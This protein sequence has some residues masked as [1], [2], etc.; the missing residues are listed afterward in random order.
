MI[1]DMHFEILTVGYCLLIF[2]PFFFMVTDVM[3]KYLTL[4]FLLTSHFLFILSYFCHPTNITITSNVLFSFSFYPSSLFF[5]IFPL[6]FPQFTVIIIPSPL[7]PAF[8][9]L[10]AFLVGSTSSVFLLDLLPS[11]SWINHIKCDLTF[12]HRPTS[13][14]NSRARFLGHPRVPGALSTEYRVL[15][16]PSFLPNVRLDSNQK[17]ERWLPSLISVIN[18]IENKVMK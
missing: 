10:F 9:S 11:F 2:S 13:L 3:I 1:A 4:L 7:F 16:L 12:V 18:R 6:T 17:P 8:C 5:H 14:F 15:V